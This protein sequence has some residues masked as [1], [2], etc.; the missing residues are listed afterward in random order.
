MKKM[1]KWMLLCACV[2]VFAGC[3]ANK[4]AGISRSTKS[5][6]TT[7]NDMKSDS[8]DST[9]EYK[10]DAEDYLPEEN[11]ETGSNDTAASDEGI[12]Y[13]LTKMNSDMVYAT[14]YQ[15]MMD[16]EQ[17]VGKVCK[18]DGL[19]YA[20]QDENTG[21]YYHYCIITD[22][23][24]CCAQGLEFIWGDGSHKYPDEYPADQTPIIVQ[25]TFETY[26]EPEDDTVYCRLTNAE[27]QV[28]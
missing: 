14:V 11:S 15:M 4:G 12:D 6:N 26:Q 2:L 7:K 18:I 3:A 23:L 24:A 28:E 16:P 22:A 25:G 27:M 19:Y 17:Y 5:V 13:D 1:I 21:D 20:G 9:D 8:D 10:Q